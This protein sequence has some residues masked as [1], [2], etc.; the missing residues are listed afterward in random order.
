[1]E[2]EVVKVQREE[3]SELKRRQLQIKRQRDRAM[4]MIIQRDPV[5]IMN[6]LNFKDEM[7]ILQKMKSRLVRTQYDAAAIVIQKHIRRYQSTQRFKWIVISLNHNYF[8]GQAEWVQQSEFK[9]YGGRLSTALD[10]EDISI[11]TT[12]MQ[13]HIFKS[14][15]EV[16]CKL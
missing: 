7:S 9:E 14:F 5:K 2:N 12:T 11:T 3:R 4:K 16:T 6:D 8:R 1:M 15:L 13:P 10:K